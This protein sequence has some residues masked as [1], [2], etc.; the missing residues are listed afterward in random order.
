MIG[1][2]Y[3]LRSYYW[4]NCLIYILA[5]D[6][7]IGVSS[8]C[9]QDYIVSIVSKLLIQNQFCLKSY[10]FF[11]FLILNILTWSSRI[12]TCICLSQSLSNNTKY[13]N[14]YFKQPE[15]DLIFGSTITHFTT[16]NQ[17]TDASFLSWFMAPVRF[18]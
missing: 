11:K 4:Y 9:G 17:Q 2:N 15:K 18:V 5:W 1:I 3:I 13:F 10:Q 16:T 12:L 7:I 14:C 8:S 6:N